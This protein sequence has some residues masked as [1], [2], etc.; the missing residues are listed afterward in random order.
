VP[1]GSG[2]TVFGEVA[3]LE[4]APKL[5]PVTLLQL[6]NAYA[7]SPNVAVLEKWG[8]MRSTVG[9]ILDLSRSRPEVHGIAM[10]LRALISPEYVSWVSERVP[11]VVQ[12]DD[13]TKITVSDDTAAAAYVSLMLSIHG[14]LDLVLQTLPSARHGEEEMIV[15]AL[16]QVYE[17]CAFIVTSSNRPSH[18]ELVFGC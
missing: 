10:T 18:C 7:S 6:N 8:G 17:C 5:R 16:K 2:L 13:A 12:S 4:L 11:P 15:V 1:S 3:W 14:P 9:R